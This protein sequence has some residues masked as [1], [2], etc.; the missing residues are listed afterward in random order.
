[1]TA[2]WIAAA[3]STLV[4]PVLHAA[5]SSA[6]PRH[7]RRGFARLPQPMQLLAIAAIAAIVIRHTPGVPQ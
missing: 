1:M 7:R 5:D 3:F 2:L 4:L 6:A